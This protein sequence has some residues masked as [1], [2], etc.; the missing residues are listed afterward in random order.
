MAM[1]RQRGT[2]HS[3]GIPRFI[4]LALKRRSGFEFP[5]PQTRQEEPSQL[6]Q[7]RFE[8]ANKLWAGGRN[9]DAAREFHAMAEEEAGYPDGKAALLINEHKCYVQIGKLDTAN[10]VMRQIR[11]LPV[12]DKFVRMI[13]DFGDACMTTQMGKLKEGVFKFEKILQSNQEELRDPENR[14]LYEDLQ[15]R[16]GFAL[17]SLEK[18]AE[19][20]AVLKEAT[21]FTISSA[22]SS[23]DMQGVH[24]YLGICYAALSETDLAKEAYLRAIGFAFGNEVE[25]KARYRLAILYFMSRAFAQAKHH[26]EAAL[27]LPAEVVSGQLRRDVYQQMS[28]VCHYLQEFDEEKRYSQLAQ[29]S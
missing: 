28:R 19:A 22:T 8:N 12:Q 1:L 14:Y 20:A 2:T 27:Q 29:S 23:E 7:T 21:S 9:E 11:T 6:D 13:V 10:E 4:P 16:R 18:Y 17:T 26:L 3:A 5:D 15:Q 24:F 25:A